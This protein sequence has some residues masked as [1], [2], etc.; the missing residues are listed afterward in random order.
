MKTS[1]DKLIFSIYIYYI[2][3]KKKNLLLKQPQFQVF[4]FYTNR[5]YSKRVRFT[6]LVPA[7]LQST[8]T[9]FIALYFNTAIINPFIQKL[10]EHLARR[11]YYLLFLS[12]LFFFLVVSLP[13]LQTRRIHTVSLRRTLQY[14]NCFIDVKS[15]YGFL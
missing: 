10:I 13:S 9:M 4:L 5:Y 14:T 2:Y 8:D 11:L 7:Y 1:Y 12:F 15:L 6:I 3:I